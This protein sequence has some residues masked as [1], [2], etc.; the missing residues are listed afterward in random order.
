M[1]KENTLALQ[2]KYIK[3]FE[4]FFSQ[5]K[6]KF[7]ELFEDIS[8][9]LEF[10]LECELM[11]YEDYISKVRKQESKKNISLH[12]K[13]FC[14][15]LKKIDLFFAKVKACK[16]K[17][18]SKTQKVIDKF[19]VNAEQQEKNWD[20][21]EKRG[22]EE[23]EGMNDLQ[24]KQ[25]RKKQMKLLI[26]TAEEINEEKSG[27]VSEFRSLYK[28]IDFWWR[29]RDSVQDRMVGFIDSIRLVTQEMERKTQDFKMIE[30][31]IQMVRVMVEK[32][33]D[34]IKR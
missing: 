10:D 23:E 1:V 27:F 7:D 18:L 3:E 22:Q 32:E 16:D 6:D 15:D 26:R 19:K 33:N 24:V 13:K 31:L 12:I 2:G 11:R 17:L 21:Q 5:A 4:D 14:S 8:I 30:Y 25:K 20:D 29:K 28:S 9:N 34:Y